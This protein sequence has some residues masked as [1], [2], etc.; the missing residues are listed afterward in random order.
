M[1]V[2]ADYVSGNITAE[3]IAA[4]IPA[5]ADSVFIRVNQNK[6][7]LTKGE[8]TGSIDIWD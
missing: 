3:E 6:L 5:G 4:K 1:I 8:E 2:A 7:W